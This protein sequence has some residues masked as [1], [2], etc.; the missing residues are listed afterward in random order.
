MD[1]ATQS[2]R[3]IAR[4][5]S[6]YLSNRKG[7]ALQDFSPH[8]RSSARAGVSFFA[9]PAI[10]SETDKTAQVLVAD[11]D[12]CDADRI[13]QSFS[14]QTARQ[15]AGG[16]TRWAQGGTS[17]RRRASQP[18]VQTGYLRAA[19]PPLLS[20][21]RTSPP[22]FRFSERGGFANH[23]FNETMHFHDCSDQRL[24]RPFSLDRRP[25][26]RFSEAPRT[27]G[28]QRMWANGNS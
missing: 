20:C 7:R 2:V 6:R 27:E 26:D 17:K 1:R 19:V 24:A 21:H 28:V 3:G 22:S 25:E 11:F 5:N 18:N 23:G 4:L 12:A 13:L 10:W 8:R 9:P 16:S 14:S 15:F